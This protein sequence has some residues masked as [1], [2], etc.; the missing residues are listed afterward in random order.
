[1]RTLALRIGPITNSSR[2][3]WILS[4]IG[5]VSLILSKA[6]RKHRWFGLG[7]VIFSFIA[8]CPGFYFRPHYFILLLPGAAVLAGVGADAVFNLLN[9]SRYS[10][11]AFVLPVILSAVVLGESFYK[12]WDYLFVQSPNKIA[13]SVYGFN[14]FGESL[15]IAEYIK[16]NSD[17]SDRIAVIGSEPQIFFYSDRKSATG[18]I[19]TYALMETHP[20]ALTMQEEMIS[21][22]ESVTPEFIVFVHIQ[23]SWLYWPGSNKTIFKWF[24]NYIKQYECIG[25]ADI[26]SADRTNYVWDEQAKNYSPSSNYWLKVYRRKNLQ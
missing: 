13:R 20:Y 15:Q 22:I 17:A 24:D 19:Y 25:V 18:H 12:Q 10:M 3:I 23:T 1:M 26:L 2:L 8:I 7:F 6:N 16:E 11:I 4:L 5:L 14:P 21:E 9:K